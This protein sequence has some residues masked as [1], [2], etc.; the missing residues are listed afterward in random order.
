MLCHLCHHVLNQKFCSSKIIGSTHEIVDMK[1]A[2]D[3]LR[4]KWHPAKMGNF[5]EAP[6]GLEGRGGNA[7]GDPG[8]V[9]VLKRL[10]R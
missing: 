5:N 6:G 8:H 3:R 7:V 2:F 9:E 10:L 1:V 4:T